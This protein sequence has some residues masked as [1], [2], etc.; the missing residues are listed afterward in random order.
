MGA[1][2]RHIRADIC[3]FCREACHVQL[4]QYAESYRAEMTPEAAVSLGA[5]R[6]IAGNAYNDMWMITLLDY[7]AAMRVTMCVPSA[8]ISTHS[9][10]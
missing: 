4:A 1:R 10:C 2:S 5:W 7:S 3:H 6:Y 9:V 8:I